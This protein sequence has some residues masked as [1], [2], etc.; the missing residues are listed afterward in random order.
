[1][2]Y[3][4]ERNS[5]VKAIRAGVPKAEAEKLF[6]TPHD[7]LGAMGTY[8]GLI[9]IAQTATVLGYKEEADRYGALARKLREKINGRMDPETGA[10]APDSQTLQALALYYDIPRPEDRAKVLSYLLNNIQKTRQGHL[11]TGTTGTRQLFRCLSEEGEGKLA[12][13]MMHQPGYPGYVDML[14]HGVTAIWENWDTLTSLNHP[15]LGSIDD[16]FYAGLAGIQPDPSVPGFH[17]VVFKPDIDCGLRY[18]R[19]EYESF[20]GRIISQWQT[21]EHG[22]TYRIKVPVGGEGKV[23]L[24]RQ[25][26]C[27][28]MVPEDVKQEPEEGRWA[29]FTTGSGIY[30]FQI[31]KGL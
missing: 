8:D 23:I 27:R 16:W 31:R 5:Y 29:I 17:R 24:P 7:I 19:A 18:V 14:D 13:S 12:V 6:R 10:Y 22:V 1:V 15:A 30:D 26:D 21:D 3:F 2:G 25:K 20:M 28:I 9:T 4:E 11:S